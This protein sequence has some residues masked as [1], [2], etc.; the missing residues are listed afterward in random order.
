MFSKNSGKF[1]K[2]KTAQRKNNPIRENSPHLV[3]LQSTAQQGRW[4][5]F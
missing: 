1:C 2:L 4:Y 5:D 3:T